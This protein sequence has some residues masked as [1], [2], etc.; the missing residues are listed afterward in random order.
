MYFHCKHFKGL[1]CIGISKKPNNLVITVL[2]HDLKRFTSF[3]NN[4]MVLLEITVLFL[5]LY[6]LL[7]Y[8]S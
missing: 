5:M 6:N 1:V 7:H 4:E 3:R 8:H 2:W